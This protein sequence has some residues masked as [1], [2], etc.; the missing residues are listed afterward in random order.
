ML[1]H[2]LSRLGFVPESLTNVGSHSRKATLSSVC[3]KAGMPRDLCRTLGGHAVQGDR[4]V[5]EYS[6]DV[7]AFP[8]LELGRLL[9]KV[10]E[11][12]FMPDSSR[13]GRWRRSVPQDPNKTKVVCKVCA[14]SRVYVCIVCVCVCAY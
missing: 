4:S 2:L 3:A 1:R 11:G 10:R 8:L 12:E 14:V 13:S 5:D 9:E 7:L 6:R